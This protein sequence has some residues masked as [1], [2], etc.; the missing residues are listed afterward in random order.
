M[1]AV[2]RR[3]EHGK[4]M[5]H[6]ARFICISFIALFIIR[7]NSFYEFIYGTTTDYHQTIVPTYT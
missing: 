6:K 3:V 4:W 5:P 1:T 2:F 7:F